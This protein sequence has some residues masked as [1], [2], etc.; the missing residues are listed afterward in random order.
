MNVAG[1]A[2][3][4]TEL[5]GL[6]GCTALVTGGTSGLG[7]AVAQ[8]LAAAGARVLVVGRDV[9]RGARVVDAIRATG[10]EAD[11]ETADLA[12]PGEIE[13]LAQRIRHTYGVV[14][15]LINAA[16]VCVTKPALQTTEEDWAV[17][18]DVNVRG[19]FLMCKAFGAA[20]IERGS[21][22]IVNFAST[23]AVVGVPD[24]AAY[25]ASKG[26]VVQL[27]RSLAVE[28]IKHGINVNCVAPTEFATPMTEPFLVNDTYANWVSEAIPIGRIGQPEEIVGAVL[29]L[30]SP[31]SAMVVGHTLLVDGGR[32]VI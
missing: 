6:D 9:E 15:I 25:T 26:A 13:S 22:K 2:R 10:G 32:T 30:V 14:D 31:S 27:T 23:D 24:L 8:G 12:T 5:F 16:G 29:F 1:Q 3:Y 20:M 4:L 18:F 28:W 17:T 19:T 7:A 11:Y 21:G